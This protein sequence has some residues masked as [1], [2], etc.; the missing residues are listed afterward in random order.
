MIF[1]V[2]FFFYLKIPQ[3]LKSNMKDIKLIC[4]ITNKKHHNTMSIDGI[5]PK[6]ENIF[7]SCKYL[8]QTLLINYNSECNNLFR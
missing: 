7:F 4:Q 2:S 5:S 3:S 8:P 1:Q 6:G